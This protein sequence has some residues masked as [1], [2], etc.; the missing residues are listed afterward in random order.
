MSLC[1]FNGRCA[2]N[3][4]NRMS[5]SKF[6]PARPRAIGCVGAGGCTM[7]SQVRQASRSRTCTTT[8]H[9]AGTRSSVS[10]A[11]SPSLRNFVPEQHGQTV[12]AGCTR[13]WRGRCSGKGRRAGF[14]VVAG[15]SAVADPAASDAISAFALSS[16]TFSTSSA[17]CSSSR[18]RNL[19][20]RSDEAPNVSRFILAMVS[21][22]L[23]ISASR[24]R[25]RAS[26]AWARS[27]DAIRAACSA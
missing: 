10:V 17:S 3:L 15:D 4:P 21:F 11:S 16:A 2:P 26:A 9:R 20:L 8:F 22:R 19:T 24:L 7:V 23:A 25:A 12:G 13:R 27:S 14:L 18:S 6:G 1:R 5:A